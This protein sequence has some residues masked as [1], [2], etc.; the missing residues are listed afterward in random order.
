MMMM[1]LEAH[2]QQQQQEQEREQELLSAAKAGSGATAVAR[3]SDAAGTDTQQ[4]GVQHT[5]VNRFVAAADAAVAAVGMPDRR[6]ME[7][8]AGVEGFAAQ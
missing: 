8:A 4:H 3:A 5:S 7:D 6:T 1:V 2:K